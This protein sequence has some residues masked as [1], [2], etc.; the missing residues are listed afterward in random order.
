MNRAEAA[1]LR[2]TPVTAAE[3][4]E[5]RNELVASALRQRETVEDRANALGWS[6]INTGN[7]AAADRE[8]ADL[9]AVTAADI[10]RVARRYLTD[11]RSIAI[12]MRLGQV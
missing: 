2:D 8:I 3:L 11:Q 5:A 9:Q 7:A 6:L 12:R 10:Q 4:A 1:R